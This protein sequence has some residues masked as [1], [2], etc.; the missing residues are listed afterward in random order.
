MRTGRP[1]CQIRLIPSESPGVKTIIRRL[2][3]LEDRFCPPVETESDRQLLARIEAGRRRLATADG[4]GGRVSTAGDREHE[5]VSG[6]SLEQILH[7]G[8]EKAR[9]ATE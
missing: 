7:R 1:Q 8:R 5:D 4:L 3:R 6:L 2:R 9:L